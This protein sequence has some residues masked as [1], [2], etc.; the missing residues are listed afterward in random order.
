MQN[1]NLIKVLNF[2]Q[3]VSKNEGDLVAKI[4]YAKKKIV[5]E[6]LFGSFKRKME[7]SWSEISAINAFISQ[8]ENGLLEIEVHAFDHLD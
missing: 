3:W 5:W 4:Y 1:F 6:L 8:G 7:I 2:E